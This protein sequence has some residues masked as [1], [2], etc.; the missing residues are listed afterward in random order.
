M[1]IFKNRVFIGVSCLILA[2]LIAFVAIPVINHLTT[3]TVEVMRVI[4]D[5]GM[6]TKITEDMLEKVEIGKLNLPSEPAT[7]PKQIVGKYVTVDMKAHDVVYANKVTDKLVFPEN[8]LRQM[9]VGE[10]A[11]T[12][13]LGDSYRSRLLP[14]DIVSFYAFNESGEAQIVP[15]L[16]Y[17]SVVTT[18]TS[19]KIDI[20]YASQVA[21]DGSALVPDTITFILNKSQINK[22]LTLE[23]QGKY[24]MTLVCRG[25]DES[26]AQEY[27]NQQNSY[28]KAQ[29]SIAVT[30][31]GKAQQQGGID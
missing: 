17:V 19:D 14:N 20:L 5:I 2:A 7:N 6:G 29:S 28:F 16:Q 26:A 1:K 27:I 3:S 21:A 13:K 31:I 4:D 9:Q 24:K 25:T 30:D 10:S 22:L 8:K 12:V 11:Y 15:E 18:T 23:N